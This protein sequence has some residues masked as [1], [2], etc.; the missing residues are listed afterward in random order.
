MD[1]FLDK[2]KNVL[3][4][5]QKS[6]APVLAN[7]MNKGD[8]APPVRQKKLSDYVLPVVAIGLGGFVLWSLFSGSKRRS[9]M[10]SRRYNRPRRSR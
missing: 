4:K 9:K 7:L 6:V 8:E 1:G 2:A 3:K 5:A 10:M